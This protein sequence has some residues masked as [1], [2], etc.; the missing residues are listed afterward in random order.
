MAE[1][2]CSC[3]KLLGK[4]P[5]RI[6]FIIATG[7][8]D[9]LVYQRITYL[10]KNYS[11]T[12]SFANDIRLANYEALMEINDQLFN[13]QNHS[14]SVNQSTSVP[15][16]T[17]C[18][19]FTTIPIDIDDI[20]DPHQQ[21]TFQEKILDLLDSKAEST[22]EEQN[23]MPKSA[24]WITLSGSVCLEPALLN[25]FLRITD[26]N[27]S[28]LSFTLTVLCFLVDE[29]RLFENWLFHNLSIQDYQSNTYPVYERRVNNFF[30]LLNKST[31]FQKN[32]LLI[33]EKNLLTDNTLQTLLQD[34][35]NSKSSKYR[36]SNNKLRY[37]MAKLLL[38]RRRTVRDIRNVRNSLQ[39]CY[40]S[41]VEDR[42]RPLLKDFQQASTAATAARHIIQLVLNDFSRMN[43]EELR[44][45]KRQ[46]I[47][48]FNSNDAKDSNTI[49]AKLVHYALE[50]LSNNDDTSI[51]LIHS[52]VLVI[53]TLGTHF[54]FRHELFNNTPE[55]YTLSLLLIG[56][57]QYALTLSGLRLCTTILNGDQN[58]HKYAI[59]YL[60]HDSSVGRK[61]LDAINWLLSPYLGLK[62]LWK[63]EKE[64][65]NDDAE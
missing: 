25:V 4:P 19:G 39:K 40:N 13:R 31:Y 11:A 27:P 64:K 53:C 15:M 8:P 46:L 1:S 6:N 23:V 59:T 52:I 12:I 21:D 45:Y 3:C 16:Q 48:G 58:E 9:S 5:T 44:V 24:S 61:I 56:Q 33:E 26:Q 54:F 57:R 35:F 55:I 38:P 62:N 42:L 22:S 28:L 30:S 36:A 51:P 37:D 20:S 17:C 43:E 50:L 41:D 65:E 49:A 18:H 34:L 60:T 2:L 47:V 10:L 14:S 63:E 7:L 29:Q 32:T